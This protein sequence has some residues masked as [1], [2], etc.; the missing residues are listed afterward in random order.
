MPTQPRTQSALEQARAV[1]LRGND[2]YK[3]QKY[4]EAIKAYEEAIELCPA[5]ETEDLA[6]FYQ[7]LAAVYDA[8]VSSYAGSRF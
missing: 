2:L 1:K 4:N 5:S 6:V 8:L 7:N 3:Q